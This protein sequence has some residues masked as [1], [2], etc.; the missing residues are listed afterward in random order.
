MNSSWQWVILADTIR[1]VALGVIVTG[2]SRQTGAILLQ[3]HPPEPASLPG[4][5]HPGNELLVPEQPNGSGAHCV[6]V[7]DVRA[8][9]VP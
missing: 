6:R 4:G 9:R 7:V 8:L 1:F 5:P 3:L 2:I